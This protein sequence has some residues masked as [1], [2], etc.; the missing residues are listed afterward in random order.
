MTCSLD[1]V[2]TTL[3]FFVCR[4]AFVTPRRGCKGTSFIL[5]L[6]DYELH[7]ST[8]LKKKLVPLKLKRDFNA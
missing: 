6:V 3:L 5:C 2:L 1:P 4:S 8:K 7:R